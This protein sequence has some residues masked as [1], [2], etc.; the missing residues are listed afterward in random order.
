MGHP[1]ASTSRSVKPS[2]VVPRWNVEGLGDVPQVVVDTV[3]SARA[4][5]TRRAYTLEW[6]LFVEWFSSHRNY[7]WRCL[8]RAVLSCQ[9]FRLAN[10]HYPEAQICIQGSH[11]AFQGSGGEHASDALGGGRLSPGSAL[12]H[13]RFTKIC[14]LYADFRTSEQLFIC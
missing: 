12:L 3:S 4:P 10:S 8:I 13:L 1:L 7:P 11:H 14:G 5:S 6:D 9:E 2:C